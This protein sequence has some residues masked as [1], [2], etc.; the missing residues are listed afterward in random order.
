MNMITPLKKAIF[1]E[2]R[3][4]NE[5]LAV[6]NDEN[7]NKLL[8]KYPDRLN[9]SLTGFIAVKKVFTAYSFEIPATLKSKHR[10]GMSRMEYPY[11]LTPK[12]LVLFSEVD[13]MVIK[14]QGG[15][16]AFLEVCSQID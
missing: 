13:A 3:K 4:Q 1:E 14:I 10:Y 12:R 16:E 15:I 9:L 7:L 11:F 2:L 5:E 6:I 8:F